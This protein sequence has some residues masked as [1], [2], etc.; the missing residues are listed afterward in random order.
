MK[1]KD[2][3]SLRK[4][5]IIGLV[6]VVGYLGSQSMTSDSSP[7]GEA[8]PPKSCL[9]VVKKARGDITA[10]DYVDLR[11]RSKELLVDKVTMTLP[12]LCYYAKKKAKI[13]CESELI[14]RRNIIS[15]IDPINPI[16]QSLEEETLRMCEEGKEGTCELISHGGSLSKPSDIDG[17]KGCSFYRTPTW[18]KKLYSD[19]P[20]NSIY[21]STLHVRAT[22]SCNYW[23][24]Y[25]LC[26]RWVTPSYQEKAIPIPDPDRIP[27]IIR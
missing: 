13:A 23:A 27:Q 21:N 3:E 12:M 14:K 24:E 2:Q 6:L 22:L 19:P 1:K 26:G 15:P 4:I 25:L 16:R 5:V 18:E 10:S 17:L 8:A 7:I 20:Y 11:A 9:N